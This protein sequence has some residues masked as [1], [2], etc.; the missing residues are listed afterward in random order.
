MFFY[1]VSDFDTLISEDTACSY[2][3]GHLGDLALAFLNERNLRVLMFES[4]TDRRFRELQSFLKGVRVRPIERLW[5]GGNP[6]PYKPIKKLIPQAGRHTFPK[7]EDKRETSVEVM[8]FIQSLM[9]SCCNA[10]C[11]HS[12]ISG[13]STAIHY[14]NPLSLGCKLASRRFSLLK[15]VKLLGAS[16][17]VNG[18]CLTSRAR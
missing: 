1:F 3:G 14:S 8:I 6:P 16:R 12:N 10:R 17:I 15:F 18:W 11:L 5:Q 7:G 4:S 13:R 2:K 9:L